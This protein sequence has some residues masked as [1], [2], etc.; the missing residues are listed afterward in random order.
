MINADQIT[1]RIPSENAIKKEVIHCSSD[2]I[3][4][5]SDLA[6]LWAGVTA[7]GTI[8]LAIFAIAAW[9]AAKNQIRIMEG[10]LTQAE[11]RF[12]TQLQNENKTRRKDE[13]REATANFMRAIHDLSRAAV[14][15]EH[16]FVD[17][18][19]LVFQESMIFRLIVGSEINEYEFNQVMKVL[20]RSS[21]N[22]RKFSEDKKGPKYNN[23]HN[24]YGQ[25]VA[26]STLSYLARFDQGDIDAKVLAAKLKRRFRVDFEAVNLRS[27]Q[28]SIDLLKEQGVIE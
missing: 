25:R 8:V 28:D 7:V 23:E 2:L 10:E 26:Q 22:R 5:T 18:R 3:S 17:A 1:C 21:A 13:L 14:N 20:I 9:N 6:N 16:N 27:D 4:T 11:E 15:P 12:K 24:K 19:T